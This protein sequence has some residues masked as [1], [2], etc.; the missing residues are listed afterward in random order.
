MS[1]RERS[2]E[3]TKA[4]KQ[5][6]G[7]SGFDADAQ[8]YF[9][10][11]GLIDSAYT[12]PIS[13]FVLDLKSAALWSKFDRLWIL[14]NANATAA[15]TCIKS[16]EVATPINNPTFTAGQGYAGNGTSSYLNSDF[17]P[18]SAA[19]NYT[20]DNAHLSVFSRTQGTAGV[21]LGSEGPNSYCG[22]RLAGNVF[23]YSVNGGAG[24]VA[25]G[26]SVGHF[27]SSRTGALLLSA[28]E[29]GV[30][31]ES[32]NTASI[33]LPNRNFCI[34][35]QNTGG[36]VFSFSNHQLALVSIGSG[37][38]AAEASDYYDAVSTLKTAIGF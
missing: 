34:L 21:D 20:Q 35:A 13:Q 25:N 9:T 28:Y 26:N 7:G 10:S 16:L 12:A 15:L 38:N 24:S 2:R 6:Y 11:V 8:A 17:N 27:I 4:A 19:G 22:P 14:A 31:L 32:D 23:N 3:R 5:F 30:L 37:F 1:F 29:D 33:G 18:T 36:G